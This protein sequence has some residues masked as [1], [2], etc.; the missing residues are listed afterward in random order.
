VSDPVWYRTVCP[1][2]G[3][4]VPARRP[5]RDA[6]PPWPVEHLDLA[7]GRRCRGQFSVVAS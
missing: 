6:L 4:S 3:A 7:T 5:A 1:T 2:C